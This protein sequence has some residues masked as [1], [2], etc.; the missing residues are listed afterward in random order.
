MNELDQFFEKHQ[1]AAEFYGVEK[2]Y[3]KSLKNLEVKI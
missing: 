2:Q 1:D 3:R